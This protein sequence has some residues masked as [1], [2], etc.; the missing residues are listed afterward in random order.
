MPPAQYSHLILATTPVE[1]I[2]HRQ[3]DYLDKKIRTT[4]ASQ[5]QVLHKD[6]QPLKIARHQRWW[7]Y[8]RA[9]HHILLEDQTKMSMYRCASSV[10]G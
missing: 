3:E 1:K 8:I 6:L 10:A 5:E 7:L 2:K 9:G 4:P